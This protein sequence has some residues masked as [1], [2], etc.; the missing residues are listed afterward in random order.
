[1]IPS[2][3]KIIRRI[4]PFT[5][6]QQG[7]FVDCE[8]ENCELWINMAGGMCSKKYQAL[9]TAALVRAYNGHHALRLELS[10][11]PGP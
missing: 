9:A 1:M 5:H 8:R 3:P 6:L 4:C 10:E 2:E 11:N 7:Y